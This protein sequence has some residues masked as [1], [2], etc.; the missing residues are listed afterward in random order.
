MEDLDDFSNFSFEDFE[1]DGSAGSVDASSVGSDVRLP[2]GAAL[3]VVDADQA[4]RDYLASQL[5]EGT[6]TV[7][8]LS[9]LELRLGL[10]PVVVVL[11]PSC[12]DPTEHN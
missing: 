12:T 1:Q 9:E 3:A 10:G 11:G 8:S 6:A 2:N 7:G 5:G 4:V